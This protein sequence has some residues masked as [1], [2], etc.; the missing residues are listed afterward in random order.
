V[1]EAGPSPAQV[2]NDLAAQARFWE[3]RD[4]D[5]HALCADAARVIRAY[6]ADERIDGRTR[7]G[8]YGRLL[9]RETRTGRGLVGGEQLQ[10]SLLRG[11][12]TLERV[13]RVAVQ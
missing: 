7:N 3:K 4:R 8:V 1:I 2:A 5:I 12:L 9:D 11:R 10:T 6:L 13:S